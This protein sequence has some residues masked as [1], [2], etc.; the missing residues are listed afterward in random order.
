MMARQPPSNSKT[1]LK[2]GM[3]AAVNIVVNEL[4]DV[5]LVPNRAV[6]IEDGE[7]VVYIMR[8]NEMESVTIVLGASSDINS[9]VIDGELKEGNAII[10]N[11]PIG[12][13]SNGPPPFAR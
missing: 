12:F 2:P 3:T 4:E 8:D 13:D 5:L 9:E 7:R 6:R 11:P 10:L 1:A